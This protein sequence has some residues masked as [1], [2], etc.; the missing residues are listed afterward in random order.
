VGFEGL[1]MSDDLEMGALDA[2]GALP[3][4]SAAALRAGCD[5]LWVCSR[6]EEYPECV[7]RVESGASEDRRAEA[8][9][10]IEAYAEA[11]ADLKRRAVPPSRPLEVLAAHVAALRETIAESIQT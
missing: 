6:I 4:R 9:G 2:F 11:L 3:D 10:R 8:S 7:A 1:A 5:L